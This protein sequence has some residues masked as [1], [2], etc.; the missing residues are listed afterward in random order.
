[1]HKIDDS[2]HKLCASMEANGVQNPKNLTYYEF[3]S[4]ISYF[5]ERNIKSSAP[6]WQQ[7]Q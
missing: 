1:M 3:N 5:E 4:K 6:Q 7:D 2:F